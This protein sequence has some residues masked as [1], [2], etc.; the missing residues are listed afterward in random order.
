MATENYVLETNKKYLLKIG[1]VV[2][3]ILLR[4]FPRSGSIR[5]VRIMMRACIMMM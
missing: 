4:W 3:V 5:S 2:G 1:V